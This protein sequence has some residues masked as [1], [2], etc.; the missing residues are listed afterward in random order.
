MSRKIAK[1]FNDDTEILLVPTQ[2]G[3]GYRDGAAQFWSRN[4]LVGLTKI[5][6]GVALFDDDESVEAFGKAVRDAGLSGRIGPTTLRKI[7]TALV[8]PKPDLPEEPTHLGA[9][10]KVTSV[11][12]TLWTA[13]SREANGRLVWRSEVS[14]TT[15]YW[16]SFEKLNVT[17]KVVFNG[18]D[19]DE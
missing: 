12:D 9:K 16:D 13:A 3:T 6:E 7:L 8:N 14:G 18:W 15:R 17:I 2:D 11:G 19:E 4:D 1:Y 10:I 5:T